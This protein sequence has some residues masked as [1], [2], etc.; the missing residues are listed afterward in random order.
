MN[1]LYRVE[2]TASGGRDGKVATNDGALSAR[3]VMPKELGGPGGEGYNPEQ[4]FAS[5][6][7]AC[8]LGALKFIAGQRKVRIGDDSTVTAK[9]GLGERDE[10]DLGF[11]LDVALV[12][13]LP[14][15]DTAVANEMIMEAHK[16]CPYSRAT[17]EGLDVRLSLAQ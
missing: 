9:V 12:V 13:T 17:R 11:V 3:M 16:A 10:N 4:L 6:Y 8:Y 2:A 15:L 1:I 7:A 5:G 14:G